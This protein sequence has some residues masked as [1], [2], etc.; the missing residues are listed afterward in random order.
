MKSRRN[1][2][3]FG[4]IIIA[5]LIFI[6][7]IIGICAPKPDLIETK[8]VIVDIVKRKNASNGY[9]NVVYIDYRANGKNYK[10]VEF[11]NYE[12]TMQVDDKVAILYDPNNPEHIEVKESDAIIYILA[13]TSGL[14]LIFSISQVVTKQGNIHIRFR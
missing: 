1:R 6:G 5:A 12:S 10:H 13:L 3:S 2:G 7:S 4:L 8:G 9:D 11:G 14:L